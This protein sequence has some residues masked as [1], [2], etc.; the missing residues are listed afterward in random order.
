MS[1]GD[2]HIGDPPSFSEH[3]F[4]GRFPD[5]DLKSQAIEATALT[6]YNIRFPEKGVQ[7]FYEEGAAPLGEPIEIAGRPG[8]AFYGDLALLWPEEEDDENGVET[9]GASIAPKEGAEAQYRFARDMTP[10]GPGFAVDVYAFCPGC[11]EV[12][13]HDYGC[14]LRA[15]STAYFMQSWI[16]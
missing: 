9:L 13:F 2:G 5:N 14:F 11:D 16:E 15:E 8:I 3:N 1:I 7:G 6:A 10:H 4:E 12:H